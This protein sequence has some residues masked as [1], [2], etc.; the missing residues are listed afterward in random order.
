[1]FP[2]YFD[3]FLFQE[4]NAKLGGFDLAKFGPKTGENDATTCI[5]GTFAYMAPEYAFKGRL[6]TM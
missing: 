1:M 2:V 3:S 4:F 6:I 5:K